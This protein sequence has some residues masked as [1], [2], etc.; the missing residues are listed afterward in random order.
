[1]NEKYCTY[2][3]EWVITHTYQD[4]NE[5]GTWWQEECILCGGT[6]LLE[7]EPKRSYDERKDSHETYLG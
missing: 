6:E 5:S 3:E 4:S 1:M 2:C 7:Y